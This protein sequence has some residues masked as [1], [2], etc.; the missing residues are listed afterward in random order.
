MATTLSLI[1]SI[2]TNEKYKPI[3]ALIKGFRNGVVYGCKVRFPHS[4]VMTFLFKSGTL[5]EKLQGILEATYIHA[6]NLAFFTVIY[7]VIT[8]ALQWLQSEKNVGHIFLAASIAGYTVFGNYNKVNEQVNLYLLSRI[9]YGLAQL[10]VKKGYLPKPTKE[11]FPMFA[12]LVWGIALLLFEYEQ[13][14]LQTSMKSSMTYL[15]DDSNNW[16]SLKD[17]LIYNK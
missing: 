3:L 17:F 8:G 13:E 14:I 7:K 12:A 5:T 11:P 1:N 9:I 2:L 4:L 10:S 6:K 15:Y 16:H